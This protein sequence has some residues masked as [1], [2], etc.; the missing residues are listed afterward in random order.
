[1]EAIGITRKTSS[2][3]FILALLLIFGFS[4]KTQS[5]SL[6]ERKRDFGILLALA[7]TKGQISKQAFLESMIL[8]FFGSLLAGIVIII[9]S[10]FGPFQ[11]M[12]QTLP[13]TTVILSFGLPYIGSGMAGI[14]NLVSILRLQ[15]A[16]ILRQI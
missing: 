11:G 12:W 16:D 13:Q 3:L 9:L 7:W 6:I 1:M 5:S 4:V 8:G 10:F 15:S 14:A 2:M